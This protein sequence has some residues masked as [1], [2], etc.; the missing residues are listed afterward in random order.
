LHWLCTPVFFSNWLIANIPVCC[1]WYLLERQCLSWLM[2][3]FFPNLW[4]I[5]L[6]LSNHEGS[7]GEYPLKV[8]AVQ[9]KCSKVRT[10]KAKALPF[11][12]WILDLFNNFHFYNSLMMQHRFWLRLSVF[13]GLYFSISRHIQE[14]VGFQKRIWRRGIKSHS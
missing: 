8:M 1:I 7:T 9:T 6:L 13:Q 5:N 12:G 3:V 4:N 10:K 14:D 11:L 2:K